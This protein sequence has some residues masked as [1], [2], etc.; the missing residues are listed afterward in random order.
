MKDLP[1]ALS[2]LEEYFMLSDTFRDN[3]LEAKEFDEA[4]IT[5]TLDHIA[6]MRHLLTWATNQLLKARN[7]IPLDK[8]YK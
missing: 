6:V 4:F 3:L 8:E 5:D 1:S 2:Y 7:E